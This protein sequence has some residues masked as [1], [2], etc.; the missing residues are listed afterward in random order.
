MFITFTITTYILKSWTQV[1][2]FSIH[3]WGSSWSWSN[4]SWIY[5]YLCNQWRCEFEY[6]SYEVYS[7]QHYVIKFVSD[8]RQVGGFLQVLQFPPPIKWTQV[9]PFSI[10]YLLVF[11]IEW[12]GKRTP[13]RLC[14]ACIIHFMFSDNIHTLYI[15]LMLIVDYVSVITLK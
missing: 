6:R 13:L 8:M 2:P 15:H 7:I 5:N 14:K 9:P 11:I 12:S 1:M 4:G 10:H 3:Y